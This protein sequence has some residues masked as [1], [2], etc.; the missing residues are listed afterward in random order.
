MPRANDASSGRHSGA[1]RPSS[2]ALT[3]ARRDGSPQDVRRAPSGGP[4]H[5]W[6]P[7][8]LLCASLRRLR[9]TV[10]G[11]CGGFGG[12][13]RAVDPRAVKGSARQGDTAPSQRR[14]ERGDALAMSRIEYR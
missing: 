6:S 4:S 7:F 3:R 2:T 14:F 13:N 1:C 10:E 12:T 5:E 8:Q 9:S 11:R